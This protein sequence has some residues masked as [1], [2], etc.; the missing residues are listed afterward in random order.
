LGF[1]KRRHP[2]A[3]QSGDDLHAAADSLL[4]EIETDHAG[5]A[6]QGEAALGALRMLRDSGALPGPLYEQVTQ[7]LYTYEPYRVPQPP[8]PQYPR[9]LEKESVQF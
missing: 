7:L 6:E 8:I 5:A 9:T 4:R 3:A 1:G 2:P